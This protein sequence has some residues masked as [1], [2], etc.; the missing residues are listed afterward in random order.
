MRTNIQQ[1]CHSAFLLCGLINSFIT[2]FLFFKVSGACILKSRNIVTP[3]DGVTDT[4]FDL[5]SGMLTATEQHAREEL[6][7]AL[8]TGKLDMGLIDN[9]NPMQ[10]YN[11]PDDG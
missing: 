2:D 10:P 7:T 9:I 6:S 1:R 11:T 4:Q 5:K 8:A 3:L